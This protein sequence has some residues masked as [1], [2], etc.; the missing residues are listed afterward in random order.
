[1]AI[2]RGTARQASGRS[3]QAVGLAGGGFVR[4][5][6]ADMAALYSHRC[7]VGSD[8]RCDVALVRPALCI[9]LGN[10]SSNLN[11]PPTAV[12]GNV[13]FS[14]CG[15]PDVGLWHISGHETGWAYRV[16]GIPTY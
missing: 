12:V 3:T 7:D 6:A 14:G 11:S 10:R 15:R 9:P 16:T 13:C 1:M 2:E 4:T 5:R 8:R